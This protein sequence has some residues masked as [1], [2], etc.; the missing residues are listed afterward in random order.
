[1]KYFR[2]IMFQPLFL[3]VQQKDCGYINF[4]LSQVIFM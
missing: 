1:M 2:A 3:H 4:D